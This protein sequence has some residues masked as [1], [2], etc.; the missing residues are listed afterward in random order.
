MRYVRQLPEKQ[1]DKLENYVLALGIRGYKT[2][3][4][5]NGFVFT[6]AWKPE[7]HRN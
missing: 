5:K 4:Q 3:G 1:A 6:E 7:D 2:D